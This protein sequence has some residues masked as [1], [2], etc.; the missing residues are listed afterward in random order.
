VWSAPGDTEPQRG[1]EY[2]ISQNNPSM[3]ILRL[4][5]KKRYFR[6]RLLRDGGWFAGLNKDKH[7][8]HSLSYK[9]S[10]TN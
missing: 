8:L 3:P 4:I 1:A 9:Q 7:P 2:T 10:D 5:T 6:S